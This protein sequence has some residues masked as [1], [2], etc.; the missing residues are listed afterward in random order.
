MLVL[1]RKL[2]GQ[3][4]I[5]DNVV[6]TIVDIRGGS[7]WLGVEAPKNVPVHRMEVFEAIQQNQPKGDE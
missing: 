3:I 1:S 4:V 5:G 7:V 2:N 6:I